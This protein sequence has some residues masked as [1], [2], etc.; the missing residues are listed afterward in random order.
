M[1]NCS[2]AEQAL[3][4]HANKAKALSEFDLL[5]VLLPLNIK[6][7]ILISLIKLTALGPCRD[8]VTMP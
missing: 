1:S 6:T 2:R 7:S 3:L 8:Y 4:K 5:G